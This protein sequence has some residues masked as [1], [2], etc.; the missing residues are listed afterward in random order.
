[1][2]RTNPNELARL[3]RKK[4]IKSKVRGTAERPRLC[5][6]RSHKHTY[7]QIIDD[8]QGV[9]LVEASTLSKAF[10]PPLEKTATVETAKRVGMLVGARAL[11]KNI[12]RVVFDRNGFAYHGRVKAVAEGAREAGLSF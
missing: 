10:V 5:V 4:R 12:T 6:F 1:M 2:A 11:Q 7:A 8:T 3:R 9:T